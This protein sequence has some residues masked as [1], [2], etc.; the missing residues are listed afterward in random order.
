[1]LNLKALDWTINLSDKIQTHIHKSIDVFNTISNLLENKVVGNNER[2]I[3]LIAY[4]DICMEHMQSIHLLI[5]NKLYGSAFALVRPFYETYY[6]ALWMLKFASDK[7]IEG[8]QNNKFDFPN[9][10]SKIKELDSV[11]T[12]T[13]FFEKIKSNSW[14]T[15][16]DYAHSGTLQLSRRW[17]DDELE[18]NYADGEIIEVLQG[19]KVILLMFAFV[20]LKEHGFHTE[21]EEINLLIINT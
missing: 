2:Q 9:M 21:A 16:C 15:M 13:D 18:P 6:R 14:N 8:I 20:V 12:D 7:Q 10:G 4:F 19:T 5:N 1:M 11:Y 17:T 3:L